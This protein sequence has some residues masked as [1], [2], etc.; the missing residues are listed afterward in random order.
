MSMIKPKLTLF[1]MQ[2]KSMFGNAIDMT[3]AP[4]ELSI[5]MVDPKVF[6]KAN[7]DQTIVTTPAISVDD[8]QRGSALPLIIA[9]RVRLEASG[10]ISV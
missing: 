9:C 8:A 5:A 1:Q 3:T 6:I 4:D 2:R 7:I 10:T